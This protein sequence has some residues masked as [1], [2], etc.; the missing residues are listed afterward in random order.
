MSGCKKKLAMDDG[1]IVQSLLEDKCNL[2]LLYFY[3]W[4]WVPDSLYMFP[5]PDCN[6][7]LRE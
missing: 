4:S 5:V 2:N 6:T 7:G 1:L 3:L